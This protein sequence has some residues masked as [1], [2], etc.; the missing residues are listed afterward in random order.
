M[1]AAHR[2]FSWLRSHRESPSAFASPLVDAAKSLSQL[3]VSFGALSS[4]TSA[5]F[6]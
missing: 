1:L 3:Y 4:V 6:Q 5:A 2:L